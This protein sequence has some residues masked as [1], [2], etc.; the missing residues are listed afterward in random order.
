M[1]SKAITD[2]NRMANVPKPYSMRGGGG[3]IE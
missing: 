2:T 3:E 1:P